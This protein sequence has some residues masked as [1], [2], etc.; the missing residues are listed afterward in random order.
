MSKSFWMSILSIRFEKLH[1][2][3]L[4]KFSRSYTQYTNSEIVWL[5]WD[6]NAPQNPGSRL[7]Q[8]LMENWLNFIHIA[9]WQ[10]RI[11]HDYWK[12]EYLQA[13]NRQIGELFIK[14]LIK[15]FLCW[16]L[17]FWLMKYLLIYTKNHRT[18]NKDQEIG[19]A[20]WTRWKTKTGVTRLAIRG[21]I[22]QYFS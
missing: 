18:I 4:T 10:L 22:P 1:D 7:H 2:Q 13:R 16:K 3:K 21:D 5:L 12:T 20:W 19:F 15:L 9:S 8:L 17:N 6:Q 14:K 11:H